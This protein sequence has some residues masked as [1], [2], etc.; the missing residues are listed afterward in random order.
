MSMEPSDA[1]NSRSTQFDPIPRRVLVVRHDPIL[2]TGG[3]L[4]QALGWN[5]PQALVRAFLQDLLDC[6]YGI[7]AYRLVDWLDDDKFPAKVDGFH[8]SEADYLTRWRSRSGFH[9]PDGI[10]YRRLLDKH[11]IPAR[12]AS[13]ELDEVWLM[14]FP[15]AGY[16]ESIMAGPGAFWCNA[17]P[18]EGYERVGRRFVVMGFNYERGVGEMLEAFGHRAESIM[19]QVYA[20]RSGEANLWERFIRYDKTHPGS[21]EVGNIHFAPNSQRDYDW[22]NRRKVP[23]RCDDW[24]HF[25]DLQGRT[26][27]VN[28]EEWGGGDIRRHHLWWFRHLPHVQGKTDGF[29]HNWWT[30]ILDPDRVG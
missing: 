15:Y 1:Q 10:D 27:T 9:Q 23:S 21:A 19:A 22:G 16:Y 18:L 29:G 24:L 4:H 8:Y 14:G 11:R 2:N 25:P 17:P 20:G 3:R 5:D 7:A 13:G 12:V 6:S 30:Y 26:R 28:C